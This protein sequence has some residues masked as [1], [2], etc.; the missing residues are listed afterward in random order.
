VTR[1][2]QKKWYNGL[3]NRHDPATPDASLPQVKA[4]LRGNRLGC[5]A[6]VFAPE[7][8]ARQIHEHFVQG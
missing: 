2:A 8:G 4:R 1:R 7:Q 6:L 3:G 5:A